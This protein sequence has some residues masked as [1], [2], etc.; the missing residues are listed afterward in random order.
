[1]S[2]AKQDLV[3]QFMASFQQ[4]TPSRPS[5]DIDYT[6]GRLRHDLIVEEAYE[7]FDS[8]N[9]TQQLDGIADLL[10][11]VY[12]WAVSIGFTTEQVDLAFAEVHRSNMSKFWTAEEIESL[13][14]D[15]RATRVDDQRFVVKHSD[16][17]VIKSPSYS[18]A[19]LRPILELNPPA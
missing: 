17:K 19:N 2:T 4:D 1:V 6:T 10:Y 15:C 9:L 11:V 12:G 13:P 18:P 7:T 16:G 5:S 3:R 14:P 8:E